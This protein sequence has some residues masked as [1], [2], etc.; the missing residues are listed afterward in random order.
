M[1]KANPEDG[2]ILARALDLVRIV[3]KSQ[4]VQS[5]DFYDLYRCAMLQK[6]LQYIPD[7]RLIVD[8]GYQEA[9]RARVVIYPDYLITEE[10]NTGLAF[11]NIEGNFHFHKAT[12]R[13]YLGALLSLG[14]RREKLGDILV[15]ENGAQLISATEVAGYINTNLTSVGQVNVTICEIE[16][17]DL[18]PP[19][20]DYSAL[21]T[22]VQSLR[23][24]SVA[25]HGFGLSR[26]KMM[27]AINSGKIYLNWRLCLET[28]TH[29]NQG[30]VISFRGRGRVILAKTDGVT[31]KGRITLLLHK[32]L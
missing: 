32:Y 26:T 21:K 22:T 28:S 23:L 13:N 3:S 15:R 1:Q 24:D 11:L 19:V 9:E 6:A 7:I 30:D 5:T 31:K 4:Q 20:H 12:H 18:K 14:L 8:G 25:A 16:R 27:S 17:G 10:I 29:V 2:A